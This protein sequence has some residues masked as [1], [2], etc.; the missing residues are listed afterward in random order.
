MTRIQQTLESEA[1]VATFVDWVLC[2]IFLCWVEMPFVLLWL[3]STRV[4][5]F[6]DTDGICPRTRTSCWVTS[7]APARRCSTCR[8]ASMS[9]RRNLTACSVRLRMY[10]QNW[11]DWKGSAGTRNKPSLTKDGQG[12][13]PAAQEVHV[14]QVVDPESFSEVGRWRF[15]SE[16]L[17][18][19]RRVDVQHRRERA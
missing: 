9:R 13:G 18:I 17:E 4:H 16:A 15:R 10:V 14:P 5:A 12:A 11:N 8:G 2:A 3:S 7:A 1:P 6:R 19:L